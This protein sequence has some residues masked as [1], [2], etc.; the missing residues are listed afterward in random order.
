VQLVFDAQDRTTSNEREL[1]CQHLLSFACQTIFLM[2]CFLFFFK[3]KHF[4]LTS[5]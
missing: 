2:K 5:T 4:S 3:I 1:F